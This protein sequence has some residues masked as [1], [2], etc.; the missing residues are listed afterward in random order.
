VTPSSFTLAPGARI[1]LRIRISAPTA[2]VGQ[3]FG[4]I[5][6]NNQ[7]RG[8][9]LHLPV[10]FFRTQGDVTL[11]QT[12]EPSSIAMETGRSTC[13]V[14]AQNN[15]LQDTSAVARSRLSS[16]LELTDVNGAF[17][18][19]PREVVGT[20]NLT[21]RELGEP[22]I[23]PGASP[24]GYVSLADFVDPIPVGDEEAVN[25]DVP[26]FSFAGQTFTTLGV[27]SDG[28]SVAGGAQGAD[29][30][31]VPQDLPNPAPPN[32]V[33]A[34]F[35][36]DLTGASAPGIYATELTDG[37][38]SWIVVEWRLNVVG[39]DSLRV[40]QQWLGVNGEEDISFVYDPANLPAAPTAG[41][42]LTVGAENSAGTAGE[43]LAPGADDPAPTEDL[44][45]TST[46]GTPGGSLSYSFELK[47]VSA[48][49]GEVRT[50]LRTPL[51][52]GTTT[53]FDQITVTAT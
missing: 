18:A 6:L 51:V 26:E 28:Y 25:F 23:A 3:Y 45:V 39:T 38:N 50:T 17:Q 34:P 42:G 4:R 36:T 32:G 35:W 5:D 44:R 27:T 21:G 33:M 30:Q 48:G 49:T 24:G 2:A 10:A 43:D 11:T 22:S 53:D 1:R 15:S 12:C 46:P 20:A 16:N 8:R 14:T 7:G 47:G 41:L 19:S 13:E 37:T 31:F 40:F 29:I 52:R 9:D